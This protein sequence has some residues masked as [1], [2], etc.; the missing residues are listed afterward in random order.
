VSRQKYNEK[1]RDPR[2][3]EV[4]E[5][6]NFT[7]VSCNDPSSTLCVHHRYY[8][9]S[10]EPW[11]Y[12]LEALVTLCENCHQIEYEEQ[13]E[14]DKKLIRAIRKAGFLNFDIDR[15]TMGFDGYKMPHAAEVTASMLEWIL[16]NRKIQSALI[17]EFF[18]HIGKEGDNESEK[19]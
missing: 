4:F 6:D 7:C 8:D 3:L 10:L 11:E 15:I 5:R 19:S 16:L 1:L 13:Y 14:T 18:S 2:W 17:D 12:P 9:K